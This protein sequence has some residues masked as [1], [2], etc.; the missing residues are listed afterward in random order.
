MRAVVLVAVILV[1]GTLVLVV[2]VH[3]VNV[4]R[5]SSPWEAEIV[6][7]GYL[8]E[9]VSSSPGATTK[10]FG[11]SETVADQEFTVP[12]PTNTFDKYLMNAPES[13]M[14]GSIRPQLLAFRETVRKVRAG[15]IGVDEA[16]REAA[17]GVAAVDKAWDPDGPCPYRLTRNPSG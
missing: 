16:R 7:W 2:A 14:P 13:E 15:S 17:P 10:A 11:A 5:H 6:Q 9:A 4:S 1:A 12:P 3:L 8:C